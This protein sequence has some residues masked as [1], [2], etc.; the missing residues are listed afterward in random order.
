MERIGHTRRIGHYLGS[1][2]TYLNLFSARDM[3][4]LPSVDR[5]G[6]EVDRLK[7]EDWEADEDGG[8]EDED[9]GEDVID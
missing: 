4:D 2:D 8:D 9:G 5:Y 3:Q 6:Q 1:P 7:Y